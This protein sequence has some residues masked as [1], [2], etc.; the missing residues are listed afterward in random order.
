MAFGGIAFLKF[1]SPLHMQLKPKFDELNELVEMDGVQAEAYS[2]RIKA[3]TMEERRALLNTAS[4]Q[5]AATSPQGIVTGGMSSAPGY[6]AG[7]PSPATTLTAAA[8]TQ[9]K[10]IVS[11]IDGAVRM[12]RAIGP[13]DPSVPADIKPPPPKERQKLPSIRPPTMPSLRPEALP[14]LKPHQGP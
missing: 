4:T 1:I 6:G 5:V 9:T 14:D 13:R 7:A 2:S 8:V 3:L 11:S 12:P 10:S